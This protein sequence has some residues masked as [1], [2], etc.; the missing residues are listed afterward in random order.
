MALEAKFCETLDGIMQEHNNVQ[1]LV[2]R[3]L[4]ELHAR[5][6]AAQERGGPDASSRFD[7]GQ[8]LDRFYLSRVGMRLL[9]GQHIMLHRPQ[10][11]PLLPLASARRRPPSRRPPARRR[12]RRVPARG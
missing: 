6:R 10:A 12:P 3:G 11:P 9:S 8:F 2:A 5:Q 4:Q 1:T 7:F